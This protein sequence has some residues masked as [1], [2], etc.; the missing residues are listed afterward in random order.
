MRK[1]I[2]ILCSIMLM[3]SLSVIGCSKISQ[4][5]YDSLNQSYESVQEDY[6][7]LQTNNQKLQ[8]NC[9][10]LESQLDNSKKELESL[11]NQ[12]VSSTDIFSEDYL[13]LSIW[14]STSFGDNAIYSELGNRESPDGKYVQIVV[15]SNYTAKD[16]DTILTEIAMALGVFELLGTKYDIVSIKYLTS[17]GH[18][19]IDGEFFRNEN[20]KFLLNTLSGDTQNITTILIRVNEWLK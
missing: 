11:S 17:D 10:E 9:K 1:K 13:D 6:K 8:N 18:E 16:T 19:I 15:P 14:V 5:D 2:L 3:L 7:N 4:E 20:G 12:T